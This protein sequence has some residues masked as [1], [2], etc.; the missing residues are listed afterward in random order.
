VIEPLLKRNIA[1]FHEISTHC[2]V[3][4]IDSS[5]GKRIMVLKWPG[6]SEKGVVLVKYSE[7]FRM[8]PAIFNMSL[9]LRDYRLVLEPSWSGY[10]DEDILRFTRYEEEIYISSSEEADYD[11]LVRM[12]TNVKPLPFGSGDWVDPRLFDKYSEDKNI[13]R[14]DI[15]MNSHWGWLKRHHVLFKTLRRLSPDIEVA[16]I[17]FGWHGRDILDIM[18]L[19]KFYKVNGQVTFHENIP[20]EDVIRITCKSK[21]GILLSLKE[22]SNRSIPE[23]L[24]CDIPVIVLCDNIG[25]VK[26]F[27]NRRTGMQVKPRSLAPSIEFMLNNLAAYEPRTWALNH[28]SC[29]KT[30]DRLNSYLRERAIAHGESWTRDIVPKT[31]SPGLRYYNVAD[32]KRFEEYNLGLK[33]YFVERDS[34]DPG[35]AHRAGSIRKAYS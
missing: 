19:A 7:L 30:T 11:F 28:I 24:F 18:D 34:A 17:G 32:D 6:I 25:G 15:V 33:K 3:G 26:K 2:S 8:I 16:L 35:L 31:N 22:G 20:Y 12:G 23:C 14:Y 27:I 1:V 10:C 29:I 9:L 5:L 4:Q 13:K 21:L